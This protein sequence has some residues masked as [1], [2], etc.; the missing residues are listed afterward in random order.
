MEWGANNDKTYPLP[1]PITP[2]PAPNLNRTALKD[3]LLDG[4]DTLQ[5]ADRALLRRVVAE[6]AIA[7]ALV[8]ARP[9]SARASNV[10]RARIRHQ[11]GALN[12]LPR[13][14][15]IAARAAHVLRVAV[16]HVL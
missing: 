16:Q 9:G 12:E 1:I 10:R 4:L 5:L 2:S 11:P 6:G 14:Q 3:G 7:G 13:V 15:Q 8:L